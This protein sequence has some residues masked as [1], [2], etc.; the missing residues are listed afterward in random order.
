MA[1]T[2]TVGIVL[3]L[4]ILFTVAL[5]DR[6]RD[7]SFRSVIIDGKEIEIREGY[8]DSEVRGSEEPSCSIDFMVILTLIILPF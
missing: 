3:C 7:N 5:C 2:Y 8:Y 4:S 6:D 1:Y